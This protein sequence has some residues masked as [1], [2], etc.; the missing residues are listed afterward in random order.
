M[1]AWRQPIRAN[2]VGSD[3][4]AVKRAMKR[5]KAQ[6]SAKIV[7]NRRAGRAF[8]HTLRAIQKNHGLHVD[9]VYGPKTHSILVHEHAFDLYGAMLYRSA[10]IRKEDAPTPPTGSAKAEA[11]QLLKFHEAGKYRADNS[12]DLYDIRQTAL[13]RPVWSRAGRYV[14]IDPRPLRLL[15]Y[16]IEQGYTIGTYAICSDHFN[17]GPHGHA[18]GYAVD[19]SSINGTSIGTRSAK[20]QALALELARKINKAGALRP[21]QQICGGYGYVRDSKISACSIPA[22]DSYY[23][24]TTMQ[25]HTNHIHCGY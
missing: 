25:Q 16:L 14:F 15:V 20:S 18:G 7:V 19:I 22:A 12:G 24:G 13:G 21:R 17:D 4:K 23:G 11:Q 6:D 8:I 9:G 5:M 10:R 1:L 2:D 3:V